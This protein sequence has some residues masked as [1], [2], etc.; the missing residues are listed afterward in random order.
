MT[1]EELGWRL[2]APR[3]VVWTPEELEEIGRAVQDFQRSL[4]RFT[5]FTHAM[6]EI[7]GL[8]VLPPGDVTCGTVGQ[9]ATRTPEGTLAA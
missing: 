2:I 3:R 8:N 4:R 5:H 9:L 1:D 6:V 7:E